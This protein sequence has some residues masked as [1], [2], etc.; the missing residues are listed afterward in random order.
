MIKKIVQ[1]FHWSAK[2]D[3]STNGVTLYYDIFYRKEM[4]EVLF[5]IRTLLLLVFDNALCLSSMIKVW[6]ETTKR[7]KKL[8]L[9]IFRAL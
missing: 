6:N 5:G 1:G 3:V 4:R 2:N 7:V 8:L 9:H